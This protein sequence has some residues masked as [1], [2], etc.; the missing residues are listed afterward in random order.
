MNGEISLT[1]KEELIIVAVH[2]ILLRESIKRIRWV[3]YMQAWEKCSNHFLRKTRREGQLGKS[4][5][6]S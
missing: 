6:G 3:G 5:H 1:Y 2:D 4:S